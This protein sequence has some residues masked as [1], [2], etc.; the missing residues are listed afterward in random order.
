MFAPH[1]TTGHPHIQLQRELGH[2]GNA[3]LE[4]AT[5]RF[6]ARDLVAYSSDAFRSST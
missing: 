6:G 5:V 4:I 2:M 1:D 3:N